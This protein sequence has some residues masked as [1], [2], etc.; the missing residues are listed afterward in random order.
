MESNEGLTI[1]DLVLEIR[2][3]VK[4]VKRE[5]REEK[6][7]V[8]SEVLRLEK[9]VSKRPTRAEVLAV[10]STAGAALAVFLQIYP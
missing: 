4:E 6:A 2:D 10:V 9:S 3:D 8:V 5:Q 7:W 1:R